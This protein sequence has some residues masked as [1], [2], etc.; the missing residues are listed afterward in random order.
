MRSGF[1]LLKLVRRKCPLVSGH[2]YGWESVQLC[3]SIRCHGTSRRDIG[4]LR[5]S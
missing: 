2:W 1:H 4:L 5:V 3:L